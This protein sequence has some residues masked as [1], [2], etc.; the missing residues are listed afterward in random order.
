MSNPD[1]Y[2]I[3]AIGAGKIRITDWESF[4]SGLGL[5]GGTEEYIDAYKSFNDGV[6]EQNKKIKENI[7]SEINSIKDANPFDE[8]NLTQMWA[9]YGEALE[10]ALNDTNLGAIFHNGILTLTE[11]AKIPDIL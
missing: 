7:K 11:D 6:I 10:L 4:S 5:V 1:Y 2:G 3:T 8:I 9:T